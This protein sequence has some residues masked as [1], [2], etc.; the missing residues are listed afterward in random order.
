MTTENETNTFILDFF[1]SM[2]NEERLKIVGALAN[3]KLTLEELSTRLSMPIA[4]ISHHVDNLVEL[5]LIRLENQY[6]R[7]DTRAVEAMA[8][9]TLAQQRP[10]TKAED[11][12]GEAYERKVLADFFTPQG[13]L[14]S[15][16]AQYKK[17]LVILRYLVNKE[18]ELGVRYAEKDVNQKLSLYFT[19]TASLRRYMVDNRYLAREKGV[20]WRPESE[21]PG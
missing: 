9:Q 11:F 10:Q 15:L 19:D 17:L 8:R 12:E 21:N 14:K 2:S 5:G 7:L 3:E 13:K 16:P 1:K 6:Y 20:Y 18:F 4:T